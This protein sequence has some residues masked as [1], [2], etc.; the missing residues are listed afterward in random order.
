MPMYF[1]VRISQMRL[2]PIQYKEISCLIQASALSSPPTPGPLH[3]L[4]YSH[5][6]VDPLTHTVVNVSI[7]TDLEAA[8]IDTLDPMLPQSPSL[9]LASVCFAPI[10]NY[11]PL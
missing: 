4:L 3:G 10:V 2:D 8:Q 6:A 11:E 1:F 7:W 9:E 5:T